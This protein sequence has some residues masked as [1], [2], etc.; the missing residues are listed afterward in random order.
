MMV[1]PAT[2]LLW[3][4]MLTCLA[5]CQRSSSEADRGLASAS[6]TH[7]WQLPS[8]STAYSRTPLAAESPDIPADGKVQRPLGRGPQFRD[9]DTLDEQLIP[10]SWVQVGQC[11][12]EKLDLRSHANY[13]TLT[14]QENGGFRQLVYSDGEIGNEI[15]GSW[16]KTAPGVLTMVISDQ[17]GNPIVSDLY[18]ELFGT[19]FLYMWSYSDHLGLWFARQA[20]D[21]PLQRIGWNRFDSNLGQIL[22]SNVGSTSYYGELTTAE[23]SVWQLNGYLVDGILNMA[24]IDADNNAAGFAAFIVEGDWDALNGTLWKSDYEAAPFSGAFIATADRSS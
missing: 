2:L 8:G 4:C 18:C 6:A 12:N 1:R 5:G 17:N 14:F 19:D 20:L 23:G 24:W 10:G 15:S 21:E 13:A 3:L 7:P 16:D 22:L 9:I 11:V